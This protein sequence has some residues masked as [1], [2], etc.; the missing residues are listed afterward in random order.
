MYSSRLIRLQIFLNIRS[1]FHWN[2][3]ITY[4][5]SVSLKFQACYITVQCSEFTK[6]CYLTFTFTFW[7]FFCCFSSKN[8]CFYHFYFFFW[9]NIEFPYKILTNQK[10][11]L[12]IRNCQWNYILNVIWSLKQTRFSFKALWIF[13]LCFVKIH[14]QKM[15]APKLKI[16]CQ[17]LLSWV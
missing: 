5:F 10:P 11:E 9:C 12:V 2:F 15:E 6:E 4:I 17:L 7:V 1:V 14:F 16:S 13:W 3:L 8:L